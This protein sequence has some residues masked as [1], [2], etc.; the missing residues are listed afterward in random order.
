MQIIDVTNSK[1]LDNA[2]R[3]KDIKKTL[4]KIDLLRSVRTTRVTLE[5]KIFN[6]IVSYFPID[7]QMHIMHGFLYKE[8]TVSS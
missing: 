8:M 4:D 2:R 7:L 3:N 6:L 5:P 1:Y